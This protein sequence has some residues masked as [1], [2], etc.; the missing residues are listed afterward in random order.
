MLR[1][2]KQALIK[3]ELKVRNAIYNFVNEE[4][5]GTEIVAILLIIIVLIGV[6]V[7][8]RNELSALISSFF[9]RITNDVNT[10]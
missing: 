8:F 3:T 1:K 4:K 2:F 7:I 9:K 6:V 10:I 5:G